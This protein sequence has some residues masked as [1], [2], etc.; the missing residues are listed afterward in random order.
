S[1]ALAAMLDPVAATDNLRALAA[2]GAAGEWGYYD[3]VDYTPD[4]VPPGERRI[5]V[6]NYMA[7][8]HGMTLAALAN[9]LLDHQVQRR[10]QAQPL[11]RSVE[12]LLQEKVPVAVLEFQPQS[13]EVTVAP[14][15]VEPL[16]PVSRRI[17]TAFTTVPHTHLLSNG[18]YTVMLTN[19]GGGFSNC[20]G[21][22]VSRWRADGTCEKGGQFIYLR[23]VETGA[24]WSAGHLPAGRAADDYEVTFSIDKAEIRRLDGDIETHLEV[25][26]SPENNAEVR[27]VTIRNHGDRP[28][29]IEVTSYVEIA[30]APAAADLAHP[31][32][33]KLFVE[34]EFLLEDHALL[35]R[36]R[37]RDSGQQPVWA[38]HASALPAAADHGVEHET[39]RALFLGRGRTP[40]SPAAIAGG[41]KLSGTTGPVLD[42]I[43]SLRHRVH[44]AR[45]ESV[46]IAFSTAFAQSREEALSLADQYHEPRVVQRTFE[47]AWAN[48][49]IELHRLKASPANVQLYQRVASAVL[50][51]EAAWRAPSDVLKA[52]RR[53]Q[54]SLWRYG[55]S[56]DDSIVLLRLSQPD[57][58]S[59]L[60]ELLLAHAFWHA[61]AFAVDLVVL[62]EH[63]AGYFDAFHEQLLDLIQTTIHYPM[64]KPGGVYLLR[65]AHIPA[66]DQSLLQAA[67]A[68]CLAGDHGSLVRQIDGAAARRPRI[69]VASARVKPRD[70]APPAAPARPASRGDL[71]FANQ[72]G[73]F[74]A[75]GRSYVI[76]LAAGQALPA[77]WSNCIA[78]E[79]FGFLVTDSGSGFTWAGNSRENKLT[80]WSND[81]VSDPPSEIVFV[82]DD[83]MGQVWGPTPLPIRDEGTYV[84]EHGHGFS[85][86][87]HVANEIETELL[88]SIAPRDPVKFACVSLRNQGRESRKLS[89]V[90]FAEWVLGVSR[91]QTQMHVWTSIDP[92][93]GA[94]VAHNPF[95]ED[96][97][98]QMV[99]LHVLGGPDGVTGDRAEFV[100]RNHDYAHPVALD[101]GQLSGTTGA[102]YD[103][104]G[105]VLKRA[106]VAPGETVE[107]IFL[108][109]QGPTP[110][111]MAEILKRYQ[112]PEQVHSAIRETREFWDRTLAAVEVKTPNPAMDLLV[113]HWLLYQVLSCRVWGR[114]A[115]YQA[116]GAF[117]FR[118][119]LQDVMALV[120]SQPNL[121][122]QHLLRAAARQFE[123]GDVQHWWHP[124]LG[125]GVRTRFS[126]DLLWLPLSASHYVTVT[127]DAAVL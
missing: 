127:G 97:T 104:C 74:A 84:V 3:A 75:D 41:T 126:D 56:G 71:Q 32:F 52:N 12:L 18:K 118:D 77:P 109:G 82:R 100:G 44:I 79:D 108:L 92:A 10:F 33:S 93:T 106:T 120:Y 49:Q 16:E 68:V 40:A 86:L 17:T 4:R 57:H 30:L 94:V 78:S 8:H 103:P 98:D 65:G 64:N 91:E 28:T 114:S 36:R 110:S 29:T 115:F 37:P 80:S 124:P 39:D 105:A 112:T 54:S 46:A 96:Y 69:D 5:V 102:A 7:H 21:L 111:R 9:C 67:A 66:E 62:N 125:R 53:G 113:N 81:P 60:R 43:F 47:L 99:F 2:D 23:N 24:F 117:G 45:G 51:P 119:Q 89:L 95:Q 50:F 15:V 116:G 6:Y 1:T 85:R 76:R 35:A 121:A 14:P 55:I 88:L 73:G 34:T 107:V 13:D 123:Q 22:A 101:R 122:R 19:A 26:V 83:A 58:K 38:V 87:T 48:S 70:A 59:L 61:H 25:A 31:A 72:Y 20:N 11:I 27:R 63:P 90:Y 42:P